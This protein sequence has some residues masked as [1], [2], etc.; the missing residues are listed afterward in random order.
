MGK[1]GDELTISSPP[2]NSPRHLST[3]SVYVGLKTMIVGGGNGV[4]SGEGGGE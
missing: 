4:E 3:L 2:P 1:R